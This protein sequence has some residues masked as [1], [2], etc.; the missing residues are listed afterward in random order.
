MLRFLYILG[1]M[2]FLLSSCGTGKK[3]TA[4]NEQI[5]GLNNQIAGLNG[6]RSANEAEILDLKRANEIN[7][8]DAAAFRIIQ[9]ELSQKKARLEKSLADR[10]TSLREIEAKAEDAVRKFEAAGCEVNYKNGRFHI[11]VP[12]NYAFKS[13]SATVAPRGRE[14]LN[15]VAQVMYDNPG[16]YAMIVGHTDNATIKGVA[17]NWSLSTERANAVVRI[18]ADVYNIN[19]RRLT[20]AGRSKFNPVAEN[21]S[22]EGMAKNRRIEIV[23]N[24]DL[25]RI[26]DLMGE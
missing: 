23:L 16:I 26:W 1:T 4:A 8:R 25:S 6:K 17:D 18:L 12:D 7:G 14:A 13:G 11:V 2:G 19:P 22:P 3:L 5:L 10:G 20:A 9:Q 21:D 15:V 24:P